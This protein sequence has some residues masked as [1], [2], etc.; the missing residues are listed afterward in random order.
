MNLK[1]GV[2]FFCLLMSSTTWLSGYQHL[3]TRRENGRWIS[4]HLPVLLRY[5][6]R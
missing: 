2:L 3:R 5:G 4:D 6:L 1:I